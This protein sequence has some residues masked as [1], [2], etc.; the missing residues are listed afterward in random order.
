METNKIRTVLNTIFIVLAAASVVLYFVMDDK[1]PFL[2][3]CGTALAVKL[4]EF[5]IRFTR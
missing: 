4:M 5:F 1:H 2:Y 3:V